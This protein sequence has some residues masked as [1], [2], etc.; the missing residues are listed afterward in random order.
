MKFNKEEFINIAKKV[1]NEDSPS[2]FTHNLMLELKEYLKNLGYDCYITNK[3]TLVIVIKGN[4]NKNIALSAHFDT[5]GLMVRSINSNGTLS[6][7]TLGGPLLPSLDGEYAKLYTRNNQVYE[8]TIISTSPSSHV[9]EDASTLKRDIEHLVF[10]IDEKVKNKEDVIEL[11]IENG[12]IICY[13]PKF[14]VTSKEFLKTRFI[15]D[16]ASICILLALLK[17]AKKTNYVFKNNTYIY[18]TCYEEVGHGASNLIAPV[19]EFLAIDMGCVGKDLSGNEYAVSICAKDSSGPF[20]YELTTRLINL[21]KK[22]KINYVV[23]IFPMYGSDVRAARTSGFDFKG[24]LIG[25]GVSASH[26]MERTHL[27]AIENTFNLIFAYI[28]N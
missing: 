23:D 11:G 10:R 15:D 21:A 4:G 20:D 7:T 14:Q 22:N 8:G 3:G 6:L 9:F 2:G 17:E 16:K 1:F 26:G 25:P 13:D 19:D 24:A 27:E 12:D 5:L 18:F 28:D